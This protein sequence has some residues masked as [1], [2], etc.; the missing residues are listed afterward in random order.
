[1]QPIK[2]LIVDDET[3][4]RRFL[5]V[6][7][8]SQGHNVESVETGKDALRLISA[9]VPDIIILDL[10]LPDMD[11]KDIIRSVR[12]WSKVPIIVLSARDKEQ[13]KVD[14]LEAGA[15]DYLTKPFGTAELTA[16]LK[17]ALRHNNRIHIAKTN[18]YDY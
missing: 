5:E 8:G 12:E 6:A 9:K 15:D 17:V 11:G 4:I 18:T 13:E 1:M 10:G 3:E 7:L 2:T 16:R 14:A